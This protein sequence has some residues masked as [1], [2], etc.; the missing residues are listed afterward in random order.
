[1]LTSRQ[2]LAAAETLIEKMKTGLMGAS[3]FQAA[4]VQ[5]STVNILQ[6][7]DAGNPQYLVSALSGLCQPQVP[8]RPG[9]LFFCGRACVRRPPCGGVPQGAS[10]GHTHTYTDLPL[11]KLGPQPKG[12]L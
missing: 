10:S 3:T 5:F 7:I 11:R 9:A 12:A 1:M 6:E 4:A 8:V 2:Q